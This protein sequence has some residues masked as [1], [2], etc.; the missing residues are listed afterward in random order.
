MN[1]TSLQPSTTPH[2][3]AMDP[4]DL[5]GL[6]V[7]PAMLGMWGGGQNPASSE[8]F[9]HLLNNPQF[10][11]VRSL[12]RQNPAMLQT[13]LV[14]LQQSNPELFNVGPRT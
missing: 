12:I 11:M 9:M 10:Q 14:Q 6:L 3:R 13:I 8:A 2:N 1:I 4:Q 5:P 7:M